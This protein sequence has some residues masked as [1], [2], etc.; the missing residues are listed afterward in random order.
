ME[1]RRTPT[2][3]VVR[4]PGELPCPPGGGITL[5]SVPLD[6]LKKHGNRK[7]LFRPPFRRLKKRD[8]GG[9]GAR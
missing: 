3:I 5:G 1:K 8:D 7:P 6:W 4:G 2:V 9:Q